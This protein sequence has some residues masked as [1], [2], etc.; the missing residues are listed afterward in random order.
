MTVHTVVWQ[1]QP[2]GRIT[3]RKY[4]DLA[5]ARFTYRVAKSELHDP[6]QVLTVSPAPNGEFTSREDG[7]F[8]LIQSE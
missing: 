1:D 3:S 8:C 5:L 2:G 6:R 4:A 7:A